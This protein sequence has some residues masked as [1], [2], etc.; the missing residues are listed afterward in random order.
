[1]TLAST[2]DVRQIDATGPSHAPAPE[3]RGVA[4]VIDGGRY[5][6]DTPGGGL[7]GGLPA[8]SEPILGLGPSARQV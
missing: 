4:R 1:M 8:E 6:P 2:N 3:S 7:P 5:R